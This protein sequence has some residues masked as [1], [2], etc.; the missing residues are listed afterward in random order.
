[1]RILR[2]CISVAALAVALVVTHGAQ[3]RVTRIVVDQTIAL[4]DGRNESVVGRAYGV[5]IAL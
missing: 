5:H 4:P 1:M 3:A 2:G